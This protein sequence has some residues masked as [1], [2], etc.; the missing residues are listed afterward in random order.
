MSRP[1]SR[2]LAAAV[3]GGLAGWLC[4]VVAFV[5]HP[6]LTL[7]MDR[8]LP[9]L[10]SGFYPVE[11][12]SDTYAWT[13]SRATLRLPG[14]DRRSPWLCSVR[15]RGARPAQLPQPQVEISADGIVVARQEATND[16]REVEV[17]LA[18]RPDQSGVTISI[19]SSPTFVPG[20]SDNRELGVQV[21]RLVCRPEQGRLPLPPLG[22]IRA[23]SFSAA[24]FGAVAGLIGPGL[25]SAV[26]GTILLAGA[27][28]LPLAAGPGP[29]SPYQDSV[30]WIA[31]WTAVPILLIVMGMERWQRTALHPAARFVLLFSGATLYLKLLALLHPSKLVVD[32]VFHA[33]RFEW[34]LAGKYFFTQPLPD[35][36]QFPY[37]IALYVFA[38]PWSGL[39]RDHVDLLRIVVCATQALAGALLYPMVA[40]VWKDWRT[41]CLAVVIF[42]FVPLP[43]VVIGNANLTYAFAQSAA[44]VTVAAATV[45]TLGKRD[46]LQL[47][48]LTLLASLAFLSH[49][50][51]FPLLFCTLLTIAVLYRLVGSTLAAP[52]RAIF[53]ATVLAAS[54][55]VV[56]YYGHFGDVYK[57]LD[58]VRGRIGGS[59]GP[60]VP[61]IP[62]Q[63]APKPAMS[64]LPIGNRLASAG[65]L[66]NAA[67][68]WQI[69]L[70]AFLGASHVWIRGARDR[71]GLVLGAW[72]LT[73]VTFL[74]FAV[75]VPVEP[76]FQRYTDEFIARVYDSTAPASVIFAA[77][78][79]VWAWDIGIVMRIA[80][81]A[82]LIAAGVRA[83]HLWT[84]WF[85]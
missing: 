67:V 85:L 59:V 40:S 58:R 21:D 68:G 22:A 3:V 47:A 12:Q 20:A 24:V 9:R 79:V 70:L 7:E 50:G 42:Q 2:A 48:G 81:L 29:Y 72:V 4:L 77:R 34:V 30:V 45:W 1:I 51:T 6:D 17:A 76:R 11:H 69:A 39:T 57:S 62:E 10:T 83:A 75:A 84:G 55:S 8:D 82:V 28:A 19:A 44:L 52:A 73:C 33:H 41:A 63:T 23:A 74:L 61:P 37:S 64:G 16:Y 36:V 32:A 13:A 53:L 78:G 80:A 60:V 49:V 25:L 46:V 18:S 66:G 14:L 43:Y 38:A 65:A 26:G 15:F 5:R 56:S 35:G 31:T 71:L 54:F 27:Q